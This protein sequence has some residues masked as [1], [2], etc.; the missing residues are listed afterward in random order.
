MN[1]LISLFQYIV[2]GDQI[3]AVI[4]I[5]TEVRAYSIPDS[6]GTDV[7]ISPGWLANQVW[8]GEKPIES[9]R[10]QAETKEQEIIIDNVPGKIIFN[11]MSTGTGE[12]Y[13][14][15]KLLDALNA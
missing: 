11:Q 8:K 13:N 1:L 12:Y 5:S 4:R 2:V 15:I 7:T 6:S 3:S 10:I 14:E 9:G